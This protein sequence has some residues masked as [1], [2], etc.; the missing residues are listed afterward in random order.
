SNR[1]SGVTI[2][3]QFGVTVQ[4]PDRKGA[5]QM[6]DCQNTHAG[7]PAFCLDER[8]NWDAGRG[9]RV[10]RRNRL[11]PLRCATRVV[12]VKTESALYI[13]L[14]LGP[15]AENQTCFGAGKE[16]AGRAG[17]E[18]RKVDHRSAGQFGGDIRG[19]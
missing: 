8:R 15:R 5:L 18:L 2:L 17:I 9:E 3:L 1:A 6:W 12:A 13:E 11:H 19:S 4:I 16:L 14:S 7:F 10:V